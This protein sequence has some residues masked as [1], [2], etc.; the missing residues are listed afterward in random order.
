MLNIP[1]DAGRIVR[2][3]MVDSAMEDVIC[4]EIYGDDDDLPFCVT[5]DESVVFQ[6]LDLMTVMTSQ[7]RTRV[8]QWFRFHEWLSADECYSIDNPDKARVRL[9]M[10]KFD[11]LI[12]KHSLQYS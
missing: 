4:R 8:K 10:S 9:S 3:Q 6:A 5:Y 12:I 1:E 2:L 11:P 7:M